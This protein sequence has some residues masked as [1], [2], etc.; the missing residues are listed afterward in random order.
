MDAENA[1]SVIDFTLDPNTRAAVLSG[2]FAGFSSGFLI[3]AAFCKALY[4]ILKGIYI[5]I[6]D[7]SAVRREDRKRKEQECK[8]A[9]EQSKAAA[10][11]RSV[12]EA[13]QERWNRYQT[14]MR[15]VTF[16]ASRYPV[17]ES[18]KIL[19]PECLKN[20]RRTRTEEKISMIGFHQHCPFCNWEG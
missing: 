2:L 20:G 18:R 10:E 15:G 12:Q 5:V 6:R 19:C 3:G 4:A 1:K 13:E 16:N 9:E 14:V 7:I 11:Q 8:D 17:D